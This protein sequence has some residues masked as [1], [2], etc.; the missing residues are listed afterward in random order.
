MK[1]HLRI[2]IRATALLK[3]EGPIDHT[4]IDEEI[5]QLVRDKKHITTCEYPMTSECVIIQVCNVCEAELF[6]DEEHSSGVCCA[7]YEKDQKQTAEERRHPDD[8]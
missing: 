1:Y 7:C 3:K 5:R 6:G 4:T 2:P 8:K